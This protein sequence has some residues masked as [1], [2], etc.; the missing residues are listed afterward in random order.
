MLS[1]IILLPLRATL[2]N[3]M[4]DLVSLY[5]VS[6]SMIYDAK[7]TFIWN[8]LNIIRPELKILHIV[9]SE[10]SNLTLAIKNCERP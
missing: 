5:F 1:W 9:N 10:K 4:F 7:A 2:A 6:T 3:N 8:T